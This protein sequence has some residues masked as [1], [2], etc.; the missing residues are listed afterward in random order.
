MTV[1]ES[2][3]YLTILHLHRL[4]DA[5]FLEGQFSLQMD[6]DDLFEVM[7]CFLICYLALVSKTTFLLLGQKV[8]M[9]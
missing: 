4:S 9:K 2:T 5:L 1:I 3:E 6:G 8:L 7:K